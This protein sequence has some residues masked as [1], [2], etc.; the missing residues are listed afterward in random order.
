MPHCLLLQALHPAP[1]AILPV[2]R[3]PARRSVVVRAQNNEQVLARLR[4]G[5]LNLLVATAVAEEGLDIVQCQVVVR[6]DL[7]KRAVEHIQ[8]RGRARAPNSQLWLM[9]ESGNLD[10][11]SLIAECRRCSKLAA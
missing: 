1:L 8:S 5:E 7:P 3:T 10:Q 11:L 6:F 4:K 9:V 2:T